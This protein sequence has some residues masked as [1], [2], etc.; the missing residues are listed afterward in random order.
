MELTN[1]L[2]LTAVAAFTLTAAVSDA[3]TRRLPNW[4]NVT[5][6]V[7]AVVMHTAL[8][9]FSGLGFSLAGFATGFSILLVLWL[10]GGGGGGDVKL[11]GALGAW[12][13]ASMILRVF[14]VSTVLVVIAVSTVFLVTFV[15]SGFGNVKN[16][17][18]A[19][20][21]SRRRKTTDPRGQDAGAEKQQ[22]RVLPFAV[23]VAFGAWLVL[24]AAWL[25]TGLPI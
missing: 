3:W 1:V 11:M 2:F 5:A 9:G 19:R 10:I 15:T 23:P 12:L 17:Y 13:G 8:N 4:L 16:R 25:T 22:R 7:L 18:L 6:F 20:R 14:F 24:L 21:S